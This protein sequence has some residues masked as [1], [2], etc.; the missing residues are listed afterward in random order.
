MKTRGRPRRGSIKI[1]IT[2]RLVPGED[3]DLLDF[4]RSMPAGRKALAVK[5]G[6]RSGGIRPECNN[7]AQDDSQTRQE[8]NSFLDTF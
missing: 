4:F 7:V 2:L 8:A 3:D 1:V 6:L 5:A